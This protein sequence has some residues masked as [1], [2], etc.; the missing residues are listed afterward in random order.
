VRAMKRLALL[1]ASSIGLFACASDNNTASGGGGSPPVGGEGG[2]PDIGGSTTDGAGGGGTV[3]AQDCSTIAVPNCY[4]AFCNTDTG[5]CEIGQAEDGVDCEDGLFCTTGDTCNG[6]VCQAGGPIDCTDGDDD[7]CLV[8]ACDEEDDSCSTATA[9]NGTSCI[10]TDICSSNAICQNGICQGAPL[11][12]SGTPVASPDCQVAECDPSSGQCVVVPINDGLSCIYGNF[13]ESDKTCSAGV[14]EGTPIVDCTTCTEVEP[15][16]DPL[17]ANSGVGCA[18]WAGNLSGF[19]DFDC[20]EIEVTVPG[21]RVTALVADLGGSGCPA[22]LQP[23]ITLYDS[24]GSFLAADFFSAGNGCATFLPDNIGATN[25]PVGT[26]SVCVEDFSGSG[27]SPPY[28]LLLGEL[29]PGCGNMIV[30]GTEECDGT[31]LGFQDCIT[32]GFG[33]GTLAC[34]ASCAF[35]TSGCAAPFC[36]DGFMNGTE[37]CD[38]FD[39]GGATCVSEGFAG[40][41]LACAPACTFNTGACVMP[42]CNNGLLELGEDCDGSPASCSASCTFACGAGQVPFSVNGVVPVAIPDFGLVT[43]TA[44]VPTTGTIASLAVQLNITHTFDGDLGISITSPLGSNVDLSLF[45]GGGDDD[46]INT[47]FSSAGSTN[48]SS[49]FAPFQGV[50]TPNGTLATFIGQNPAGTW[51]LIVDDQA[52]GDSGTINGW[53]VFG[54]VNP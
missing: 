41:T 34:D 8:A 53:R 48:I 42:G 1:L 11:D 22:G 23:Y 37:D 38:G 5:V 25:L 28:L 4:E 31:N 46:F 3:C 47:V 32:A 50:F 45:N 36:G 43:S 21:S 15:N 6:G 33:S 26:Y 20:F 30:E 51:T 9:P 16:N 13:C 18:A 17:A 39:F 7:P 24:F 27:S 19:G 2:S 10:T 29:P 54:C 14:C 40:G 12:C 35:D 44:A 52:G 49:G